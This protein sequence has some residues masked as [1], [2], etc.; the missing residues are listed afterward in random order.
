MS[1]KSNVYR[2][3]KNTVMDFLSPGTLELIIQ[4]YQV[5]KLE[6]DAIG[7]PLSRVS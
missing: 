6:R 1:L 4:E 2:V 3:I 7:Q 5:K